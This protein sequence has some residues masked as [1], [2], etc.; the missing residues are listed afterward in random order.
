[1]ELFIMNSFFPIMQIMIGGVGS[2]FGPIVGAGVFALME[3]F[4]SRYTQRVELIAGL[5]LII[6]I[7]FFPM[8][9]VGMYRLVKAKYFSK[10]V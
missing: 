10:Q 4:T 3:E 8:G 9:V 6:V 1:M 7:M 5:I 2:L